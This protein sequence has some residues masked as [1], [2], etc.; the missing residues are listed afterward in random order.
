MATP[1]ELL[2]LVTKI[3]DR[4]EEDRSALDGWRQTEDGQ[5]VIQYVVQIGN[6]NNSSVL[7]FIS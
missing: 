6:I 5:K 3:L 4:L 2:L 7:F 1:D